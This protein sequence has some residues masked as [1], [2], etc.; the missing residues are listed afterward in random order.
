MKY[1]RDSLICINDCAT[2]FNVKYLPAYFARLFFLVF[3]FALFTSEG[4]A[5]FLTFCCL[6][7]LFFDSLLVLRKLAQFFNIINAFVRKYKELREQRENWDSIRSLTGISKQLPVVVA[8]FP[9]TCSATC[10]QYS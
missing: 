7:N 1:S 6:K 9:L 5:G 2:I 4:K 8:S 3:Q 10:V